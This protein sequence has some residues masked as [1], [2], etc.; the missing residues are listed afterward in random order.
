MAEHSSVHV[1]AL[2]RREVAP[3]TM[4]GHFF[5]SIQ[6]VPCWSAMLQP[7]APCT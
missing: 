3:T 2:H 7:G 6:H 4:S 5:G 1:T